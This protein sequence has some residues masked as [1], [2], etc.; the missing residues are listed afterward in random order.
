M[1]S[2]TGQGHQWAI[3][4]VIQQVHRIGKVQFMV[5]FNPVDWFRSR[6]RQ[7]RCR[8]ALS[9]QPSLE[10]A[11]RE[12]TSALGSNQADLALV[13]ISSHFASD[14]PRL[15]PL[16][17][18]RLNAKHWLGCLGGGVVGT[19][20][21]GEAHELERT[22]ALSITLVN[23]PGAE[24]NSFSLDSTQLPDLDFNPYIS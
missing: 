11:A 14:L 15:L 6:G 3:I 7:A 13:F 4:T 8:H 2:D 16:L 24:L 9:S 18:K 21:S 22:A 1:K 12:V 17:Q 19:T 10:D 20:C 23:L 5:P